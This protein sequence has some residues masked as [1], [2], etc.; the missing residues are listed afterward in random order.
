MPTLKRMTILTVTVCITTFMLAV[1]CGGDATTGPS[2]TVQQSIAD[3]GPTATTPPP[4]S[5]IR[6][7]TVTSPSQAGPTPD[8]PPPATPTQVPAHTPIPPELDLQRVAE[9]LSFSRL[10]NLVQVGQRFFVTEQSGR[11]MSFPISSEPAEAEVFLDIRSQVSTAGNEEGLL[12]LAFDSDFAPNGHFYVYYSAAN[13]RRSVIS[14]FT[15]GGIGTVGFEEATAVPE[16][17]LIVLEVP[18]PFSNHNGG[19]IAFGPDGMLYISLGDGG[20]GGDPQGN[21][22]NTSTLLGSILRID[23]SSIGPDQPYRVP[24]N[25]PFTGSTDARGEIWAYGLRNPWRFS[26]DRENGDLWAGDV[27]QNSFEEVDLIQRGGNY[28]WNTLEGNHCFSPRTNCDPSGTLPPVIEYSASKGCSVIGGYVYRGADI[29]SLTD[30]YLYGDYCSGE[31]RGFRFENGEAAGD[32][33]LIDS[34]LNI[35]SFGEDQDGENYVLTQRGRIYR[36]I[37]DAP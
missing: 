3:F 36:L 19:Q 17:E 23:V 20:A 35:T 33:L 37:A 12:G 27:G 18:E 28:G 22:Q 8:S 11:V 26:F 10:T 2:P 34:G 14:R 5:L 31:I 16:S 25:N 29:P 32:A 6:E 24:P 15:V 21:G 9:N 13:P 30:T 7:P 1:A 4:A